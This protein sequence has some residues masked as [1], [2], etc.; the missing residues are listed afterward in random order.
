M[1]CFFSLPNQFKL[2]FAKPKVD[3]VSHLKYQ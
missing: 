1:K 2:T 3:Q